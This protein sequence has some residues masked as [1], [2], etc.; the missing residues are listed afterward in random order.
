MSPQSLLDPG[1]SQGR[2]LGPL[3][4]ILYTAYI[5]VIT[6]DSNLKVHSYCMPMTVSCISTKGPDPWWRTFLLVSPKSRYGFHRTRR[7]L[8]LIPSKPSSSRWILWMGTWQQLAKVDSSSVA[9]GSSTLECQS[10]VIDLRVII[11]NQLILKDHVRLFVALALP[12]STSF[13][14]PKIEK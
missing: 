1:V 13:V 10:T 3:F 6:K 9:L 4:F 14:S 7:K 5:S 8:N 11:N 2:V 12:A